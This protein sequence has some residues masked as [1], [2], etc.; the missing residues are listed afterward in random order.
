M[1][2]AC[3][4]LHVQDGHEGIAPFL[5]S[6]CVQM[7]G[8][9]V[10]NLATCTGM[11]GRKTSD[12][13]SNFRHR[14]GSMWNPCTFIASNAVKTSRPNPAHYIGVDYSIDLE[15]RCSN[16]AKACKGSIHA[17]VRPKT[18]LGLRH[19]FDAFVHQH[20]EKSYIG[21]FRNCQ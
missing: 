11:V 19:W 3:S 7:R 6:D 18:R 12:E 21:E 20:F 4:M 8:G 17:K 14:C 13:A 1:P 16:T 15:E 2:V 5:L 9:F 10:R